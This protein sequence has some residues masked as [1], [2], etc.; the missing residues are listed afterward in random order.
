MS[1]CVFGGD[2]RWS[3]RASYVIGLEGQF[4]PEQS[5][6]SGFKKLD[7]CVHIWDVQ[8]VPRPIRLIKSRDGVG[9]CGAGRM[10]ITLSA[11]VRENHVGLF[12][13]GVFRSQQS[14]S[15]FPCTND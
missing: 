8:Q 1:V 14:K 7:Q 3:R 12:A 13:S 2:I 10:S 9:K 5:D 4:L 15:K 6:W 11:C